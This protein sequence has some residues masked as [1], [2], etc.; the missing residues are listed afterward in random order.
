MPF[1]SCKQYIRETQS[2]KEESV[3][4]FCGFREGI[5]QSP[6]RGGE[7]GFEEVGCG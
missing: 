6:E 3:P 7:M 1:S 2:K 4:C 5:S